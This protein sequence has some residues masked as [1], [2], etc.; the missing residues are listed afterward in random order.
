M[1]LFAGIALGL[2]GAHFFVTRPM[3]LELAQV[4][5]QIRGLEQQIELVAGLR[6][7]WTQA[8][9]LVCGLAD[10]RRQLDDAWAAVRAIDSLAGSLDVVKDLQSRLVALKDAAV[11]GA[12]GIPVAERVLAR[13]N[14]LNHCLAVQLTKLHETKKQWDALASM[15]D[16]IQRQS[17]GVE[18]ARQSF[19][20]L[21]L[22]KN[23]ILR[24]SH[25]I[26]FA[27]RR[28][29]SLVDI[30]SRLRGDGA[31]IGS[32]LDNLAK[33]E[34]IRNRLNG[35]GEEIVSAIDTLEI[36]ERFQKEFADHAGRFEEFRATL[37]HV[38]VLATSIEELVEAVEPLAEL[39]DI[40]RLDDAQVRAAA[41]AI[42]DA[43]ANAGDS[44]APAK[45]EFRE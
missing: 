16:D 19:H 24:S 2:V 34:S 17:W 33:L 10:R 5:R 18:Q 31:Q 38:N 7:E 27:R 44:L 32:A 26:E 22:L 8:N 11:Q 43:R 12:M 40:R 15:T 4:Q 41:R 1:T 42:L 20:N 36:L 30:A 3:T 14:E 6:D 35:D 28:A 21:I 29:D 13:Q 23:D 45:S 9:D 25:D 37:G 39:H